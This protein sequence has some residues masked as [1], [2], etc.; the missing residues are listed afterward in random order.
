MR[1]F[2]TMAALAV[3]TATLAGPLATSDASASLA[4]DDGQVETTTPIKHLVVVFQENASFDHYFGTYPVA[5]NLDGDPPF[6]A[7]ADTPAVNNLLPSPL[8]GNRDL[9]TTNPN[10]AKP[11]RFER[12][13]FVTCSQDHGYKAE[14]RAA[15]G[16]LMNRFVQATDKS[17]CADLPRTV[18]SPQV[19][20]YFDGNTVT[21][22]WN[23]A[24][25]FALDDNAFATTYGPSTPGA[26]NL[27]AGRTSGASP[28]NDKTVTKGVVYGDADPAGDV[29]SDPAK[30]V[31]LSGPNV[32][33]LL[34][35]AGIT[36]GWFQGGFALD[37]P[38]TPT[39][40]ESWR[41]TT[42]RTTTRSSTSRRRPTRPTCRRHRTP[43]S[44]TTTRRTINTT[45]RTSGRPRTRATS[46]P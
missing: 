3:C 36:W 42:S 19:M 17:G 31:A 2:V 14:Q 5:A 13:Q 43:P 29:C 44:V 37:P 20:G 28:D 39:W 45:S 7:L 11:F 24:Q 22:L 30:E 15:N 46:R 40:Q 26:L 25:H 38:G 18:P 34:S 12:S 1:T 9:R 32:G 41:S 6:T 8:N 21:A 35:Q 4:P 23:Y 10:L 27:I 16:G 33:D